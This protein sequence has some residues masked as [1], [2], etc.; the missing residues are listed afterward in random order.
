MIDLSGAWRALPADDELRRQFPQPNFD[1]A[2]WETVHVPHHWRNTPAFATLDGP[3]LYRRTF[4]T[5]LADPATG[6]S[7]Q[8]WWLQLDGVF[9]QGDV[10]LDGTYLGDTEGYFAAHTFE[11]TDA[12]AAASEH[13]LAV[14]VACAAQNSRKAKR[15][16]TGVFQHWDCI[17]PDWNPGGIWRP[18]RLVGT[19]PVR[20]ERLRVLCVEASAERAVLALRAN[21]DTRT[22]QSVRVRTRVAGTEHELEQTLASGMNRVE[23][24][25]TIDN[26]GL[27]WP[28]AMGEAVLTEVEVRVEDPSSG[29]IHDQRRRRTGLRQVRAR[30]WLFEINGERIYLKGANQGP[31]RMAIAEATAAELRHDLQLARDTGLDFLPERAKR[32]GCRRSLAPVAQDRDVSADVLAYVLLFGLP[33]RVPR[34]EHLEQLD[35]V[36]LASLHAA[37]AAVVVGEAKAVQTRRRDTPSFEIGQHLRAQPV[38]RL[39]HRRFDPPRCPGGP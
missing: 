20:M 37:P 32:E 17:D 18:V 14:E 23:W 13:T 4:E 39:G 35:E 29:T 24:R 3:L 11:V 31:A 16:L 8:R 12:L 27:W 6:E 34:R 22:Q 9:Y 36:R 1:D 28:H 26:P 5:P 38:R 15:N 19:G 21:L 33:F 10:W 2:S 25:V 30:N 7:P